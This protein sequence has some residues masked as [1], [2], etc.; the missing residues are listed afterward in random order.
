MSDFKA[1]P[2]PLARLR[3]LLL[4]GEEGREAKMYQIQ[5]RLGLCP[6]PCW[7]S[8][9]R[10]PRPPSWIKGPTSKGRG[11]EGRLKCTKF[12]FG[13]GSV[14]DPAGGAY[15]APPDHLAGLRRPTSKGR[16]G[17]RPHPFTPPNPYFWICP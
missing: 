12:N 7:W 16:G 2:D 4:R 6:R 9:Q 11:G 10:S 8:L 15:S 14:P 1:P 13:W 3:G 5:F 17:T